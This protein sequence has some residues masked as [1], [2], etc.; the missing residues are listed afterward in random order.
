L[1]CALCSDFEQYQESMSEKKAERD[2]LWAKW[3]AAN[4]LSKEVSDKLSV[5][6]AEPECSESKKRNP[7]RAGGH[8]RQHPSTDCPCA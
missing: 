4:S 3:K 7:M 5:P 8:A 1:I 6:E 2:E